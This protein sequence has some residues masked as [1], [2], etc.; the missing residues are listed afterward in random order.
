[1]TG[2][3]DMVLASKRTTMMGVLIGC[4]AGWHIFVMKGMQLKYNITNFGQLLTQMG[5]GSDTGIFGNVFDPG[6]WYITTQEAQF[7]GW[8]LEKIGFDMR[9]NVF[10]GVVNGL[11]ELWRNPA[12]WMSVGIIFGAMILSLISNEFKFKM[13][14]GELIV[15]GLLGGTL[16]GYW[17]PSR[18]WLQHRSFF[19]PICRR[20]SGRLAVWPWHGYRCFLWC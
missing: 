12:L 9:H 2:I 15:W 5:H 3:K 7:A 14:Q 16:D 4:T 8:I 17:I 18:P 6:Y 11:P 10:F 1:M 13:P 20:R 19:Y